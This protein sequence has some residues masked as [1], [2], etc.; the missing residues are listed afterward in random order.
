MIGKKKLR[1]LEPVVKYPGLK[2]VIPRTASPEAHKAAKKLGKQQFNWYEEP[3]DHRKLR[4]F[5]KREPELVAELEKTVETMLKQ[6]PGEHMVVRR[7]HS[8]FPQDRS[9]TRTYDVYYITLKAKRLRIEKFMEVFDGKK[10]IE[11]KLDRSISG[12][13]NPVA[14]I[15]LLMAITKDA[16]ERMRLL[17]KK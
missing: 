12:K 16:E 17:E 10:C 8:S 15:K 9:G 2:T 6:R 13:E 3:I 4:A 5:L 1:T 14:Y 11:K 7:E